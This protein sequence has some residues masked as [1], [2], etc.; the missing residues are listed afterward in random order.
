MCS[1][2]GGNGG[3]GALV[4]VG[5]GFGGVC[6]GGGVL[7]PTGFGGGSGCVVDLSGNNFGGCVVCV[8]G[9]SSTIL[10][11]L[12]VLCFD[13]IGGNAFCCDTPPGFGGT[14]GLIGDDGGDDGDDDKGAESVNGESGGDG[15]GEDGV[16]AFEMGCFGGSAGFEFVTDGDDE[17][18]TERGY[19]DANCVDGVVVECVAERLDDGVADDGVDGKALLVSVARAVPVLLLAMAAGDMG[20]VL[21]RS[22]SE[23]VMAVGALLRLDCVNDDSS[24]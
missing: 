19:E 4:V 15:A 18:A 8:V 20:V 24:P 11:G 5:F 13:G 14:V 22:M 23:V 9:L 6:G 10:F 1:H 3:A 21:V 12:A 7:E 16:V 17:E 2:L